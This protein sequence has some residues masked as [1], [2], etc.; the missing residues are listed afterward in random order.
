MKRK[1][2]SVKGTIILFL[3][4]GALYYE[5]AFIVKIL[6]GYFLMP[7][8]LREKRGQVNQES[9][10]SVS[11]K[12]VVTVGLWRCLG[13]S[14]YYFTSFEV[15]VEVQVRIPFFTVMTPFQGIIGS[16]QFERT[17][18]TRLQGSK[19]LCILSWYFLM[20]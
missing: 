18:C 3:S 20:Q 16:R 11:K 13:T 17:C 6:L 4:L 5:M 1:S 12:C 10:T 2:V 14:P 7:F 19:C 15:F 9:P 8:V